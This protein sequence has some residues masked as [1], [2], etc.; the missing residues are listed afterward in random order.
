MKGSYYNWVFYDVET[1]EKATGRIIKCE[2]YQSID[3]AKRY[4][5]DTIELKCLEQ[6]EELVL[7]RR[8]Y[9]VNRELID[10]E[11]I[12]EYSN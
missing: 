2:A 3:E 12:G 7:I 6:N 1:Q 4:I 5:R 10:E 8:E 11:I 9:D